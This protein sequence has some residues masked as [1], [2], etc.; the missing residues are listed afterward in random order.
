MK[1]LLGYKFEKATKTLIAA[2]AMMTSV[3]T[4]Q[5][6]LAQI[7][8]EDHV[9]DQAKIILAG[10]GCSLSQDSLSVFQSNNEAVIA[11]GF[12]NMSL[13]GSGRKSC[14]LRF[15][16]EIPA[17][18]KLVV[19]GGEAN[20]YADLSSGDNLAIASI[21]SV[22]GQSSNI[23]TKRIIGPA[24]EDFGPNA[25]QHFTDIF[26]SRRVVSSACSS[27]S[28]SGFIGLNLAASMSSPSRYGYAEVTDVALGIRLVACH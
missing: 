6:A 24:Y 4:S 11:I 20:G 1:A 19:S 16:I 15:P 13:I 18:Y 7:S 3:V 14:V 25:S 26:R 27:Q 12:S 5:L 23:Q 21:L 22:F 10:S 28:T 8:H 17:G 9:I 2:V